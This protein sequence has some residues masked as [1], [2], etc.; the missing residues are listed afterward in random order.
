MKLLDNATLENI[1]SQVTIRAI[2]CILDLKV[3]MYSNKMINHD[4]RQWKQHLISENGQTERQPLSPPEDFLSL[5]ASPIIHN[6]RLR[7]LSERS[8]CSDNDN[9]EEIVYVDSISK[10]TLF[11]LSSVLNTAYPDYDFSDVKSVAFA[12]VPYEDVV[13][14]VDAKFT[15]FVDGYGS[16]KDQLWSTV[17]AE[18]N[19]AECK[20]YCY[21]NNYSSDP[22]S[23]GGVIWSLNFVFHNKTLKRQLLFSCR[24]LSISGH[25]SSIDQ[26]DSDDYY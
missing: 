17:E 10:K 5:S 14:L 26:W 11:D 21:K 22:F 13:R 25:D 24:A 8:S 4:K 19:P 9:S 15:T 23:E 16:I 2:D 3:E 7:H 1:V 6:T 18:I 12:L 20:I